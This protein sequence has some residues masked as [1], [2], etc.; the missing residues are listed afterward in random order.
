MAMLATCRGGLDELLETVKRDV[1][2][3]EFG[4]RVREVRQVL[5][6]VRKTL[7]KLK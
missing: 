6:Q 1:V 4:P 7:R 2:H 5:G 3:K